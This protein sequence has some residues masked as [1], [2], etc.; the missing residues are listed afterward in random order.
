V[1]LKAIV[2]KLKASG[3]INFYTYTITR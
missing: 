1:K 3:L 2:M